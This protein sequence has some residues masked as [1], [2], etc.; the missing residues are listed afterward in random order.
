MMMTK[1]IILTI[2]ITFFSYAIISS[3][4]QPQHTYSGPSPATVAN[5]NLP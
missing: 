2:F 3:I 1:N 4:G 5:Q